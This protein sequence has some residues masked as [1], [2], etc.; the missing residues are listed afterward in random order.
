MNH[1]F[2]SVQSISLPIVPCLSVRLCIN[3][4]L[5]KSLFDHV[6]NVDIKSILFE[7]PIQEV[8]TKITLIIFL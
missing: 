5:L 7:K 3:N 4:P 2:F 6:I 1:T 8:K